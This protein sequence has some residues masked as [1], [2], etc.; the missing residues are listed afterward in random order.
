[1]AYSITT[2]DGITIK[3]IPDDIDPQSE[4]LKARV[5]EERA[6]RDGVA[7]PVQTM[8][9]AT[10]P[11]PSTMDKA[12]G[13]GEAALTA[14]SSVVAEPVAGIAGMV[15]A[16][17]PFGDSG[18]GARAVDA[19]R[20]GMTYQPKTNK[21]REY[22][23]AVGSA[24][25]PVGEAFAASEDFLGNKAFEMTGSPAIAA[26]AKTIPT[27]IMEVLGVAAGKGAAKIGKNPAKAIDKALIDSA[28]SI[29]Q[30]RGASSAIFKEVESSGATVNP[31]S[32][33]AMANDVADGLGKRGLT[34]TG[35]PVAHSAMV[36]LRKAQTGTPTLADLDRLREV[37]GTA[38]ASLNKKESML[39][40]EIIDSIDSFLDEPAN[41][42]MA[43]GNA[44]AQEVAGSKTLGSRYS[45]ARDL[46]GRAK[47]GEV[48]ENAYTMALENRTSFEAGLKTEFSKILRN[49][50]QRRF[51]SDDEMAAMRNVVQGKDVYTSLAGLS[52]PTSLR[53]MMGIGLGGA[54]AGPVGG[55]VVPLIGAVS[56][57]LAARLLA[58]KASFADSLVRAGRDGRKIAQVYLKETPENLR[59]VDELTQLL[60]N[61]DIDL[62]RINGIVIVEEA[63]RKAAATRKA[64]TAAATGGAVAPRAENRQ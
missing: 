22:L 26:A 16:A 17:N 53:G 38:A 46:W 27:A 12:K 55:M 1:M 2:K 14:A 40:V 30:L 31:A 4:S 59:S 5:A 7:Q 39:G 51:F 52:S 36:E 42:R 3:N 57:K 6:R 63:A 64:L 56:E 61:P 18:D 23:G 60:T 35:T 62:S 48:I 47:R 24:L 8:K 21:G 15:A 33:K 43:A 34:K 50:K 10:K 13:F 25:E 54:V 11:E 19:V 37:A 41:F 20:G 9:E 45:A 28:P 49:K 58:N 29:D 44:V 32:F